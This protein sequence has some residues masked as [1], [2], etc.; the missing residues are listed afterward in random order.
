[1]EFDCSAFYYIV[2]CDIYFKNIYSN[3]KQVIRMDKRALRN[4][5]SESVRRV[6]NEFDRRDYD[7]YDNPGS[8]LPW[9]VEIDP[10]EI[11]CNDEALCKKYADDDEDRIEEICDIFDKYVPNVEVDI[12]WEYEEGDDDYYNGTGIS[13][14]WFMDGAS[15]SEYYSNAL[16]QLEKEGL[17]PQGLV[18]ELIK[19]IEDEAV[20]RAEYLI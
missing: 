5:I 16:Y 17:L 14:G 13:E 6:I 15:I 3:M 2:Y 7:E 9:V 1:V 19:K 20:D 8:D 10:G 18:A 11:F 4:I 12:Y